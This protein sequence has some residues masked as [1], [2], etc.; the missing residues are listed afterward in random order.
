MNVKPDKSETFDLRSELIKSGLEILSEEGLQGLTLRACAARCGVSHAAPAYHFNGLPGLLS[1]IAASGFEQL[2]N[3]MDVARQRRDNT[4]R[5]QLVGVCEGYLEFSNSRPSLFTL[6]FNSGLEI[7][8]DDALSAAGDRAYGILSSA[9]LPFELPGE[10][11]GAIETM[12]WSLV[13]G[14]ASLQIGGS[15]R[16]PDG[17]HEPPRF[18]QVL[19]ALKLKDA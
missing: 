13:H 16:M 4:P 8:F 5:D 18:D 1:G 14:M 10:P 17:K 6:M 19:P 12:I 3:A 9:C 7:E 15:F 11:D 2:S